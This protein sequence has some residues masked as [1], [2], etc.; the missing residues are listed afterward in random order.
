M[1]WSPPHRPA[2][3]PAGFIEPCIPTLAEKPPAGFAWMHEIKHDGY[4]L[5][6]C[7]DG[8][9]VRL[10]TRR[11]FDWTELYPWIVHS[12]RKLRTTRFL[13]DGEAVICG[14]DGVSDFE[15]LHSREHDASVFLYAFDLLA[16][17]GLDLRHER[18]DDRRARLR[19][20]LARPDGLR[21]SEHDAG[22]GN[23]MFRH[24]C[25]LGPEGI[26]SK[27]RDARTSPAAA[28]LG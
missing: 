26:V 21:F 4:R 12:A 20:L 27:R 19:M 5:M 3:R 15:R 2:L 9:R 1:D 17:D 24:A 16:L 22:D 18:L 23:V 14:P 13:I 6:V 25:K 7:R 10:V 11:G 8:E 28:R